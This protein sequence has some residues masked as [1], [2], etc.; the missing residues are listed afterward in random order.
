LLPC[1]GH[2]TSGFDRGGIRCP[3]P[4]HFEVAALP[5]TGYREAAEQ[6]RLLP[7]R[8]RQL[9]SSCACCGRSRARWSVRTRP[10]RGGTPTGTVDGPSP[11]W[12]PFIKPSSPGSGCPQHRRKRELRLAR[13]CGQCDTRWPDC[14]AT[15]RCAV[16][17]QGMMERI[18]TA[19]PS[20]RTRSI[21]NATSSRRRAKAARSSPWAMLARKASTRP[22]RTA[23][24]ACCAARA[25][26]CCS[27]LARSM[28][29]ASKPRVRACSSSSVSAAAAIRVDAP[30][31]L[32]VACGATATA[33]VLPRGARVVAQ[34]AGLCPP[35]R[36]V[37]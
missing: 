10:P 13:F 3:V 6:T 2:L 21:S 7:L 31:A 28:R 33:I 5:Q 34:P 18:S 14:K 25:A 1:R 17:P 4:A 15:F 20:T 8:D 27:S 9:V 36:L 35:H 30:L 19:P 26:R 37:A 32:A 22:A 11:S 16:P 29:R 24:C 23:T 12:T